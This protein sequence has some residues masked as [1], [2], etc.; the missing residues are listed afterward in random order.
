VGVV[1]YAHDDMYGPV[2]VKQES[3]YIGDAVIKRTHDTC[4]RE[5]TS[6]KSSKSAQNLAFLGISVHE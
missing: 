4:F 5:L 3:P 1:L 2:T 6:Q